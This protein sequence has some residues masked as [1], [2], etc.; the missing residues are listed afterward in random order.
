MDTFEDVLGQVEI[1]LVEA[2]RQH[3][4]L[5]D[6]A[7]SMVVMSLPRRLPKLRRIFGSDGPIRGGEM[8]DAIK[9][10]TAQVVEHEGRVTGYATDLRRKSTLNPERNY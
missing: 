6:R 1:S 3:P 4:E 9:Q 8:L 5:S 2:F 10:G 7:S